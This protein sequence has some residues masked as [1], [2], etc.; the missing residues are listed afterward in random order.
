MLARAARLDEPTVLQVVC[1]RTRLSPNRAVNVQTAM[2][3]F[4]ETQEE[5]AH[6]VLGALRD[7]VA[8]RETRDAA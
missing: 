2:R 6:A 4:R 7:R 5:E 8:A 3:A 1:A